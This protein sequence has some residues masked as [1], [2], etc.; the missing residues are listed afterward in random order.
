[1]GRQRKN[2]STTYCGVLLQRPLRAKKAPRPPRKIILSYRRGPR[3]CRDNTAGTRA[4]A[5]IRGRSGTLLRPVKA[6]AMAGASAQGV[7]SIRRTGTETRHDDLQ[8]NYATDAGARNPA[9]DPAPA[10]AGGRAGHPAPLSPPGSRPLSGGPCSVAVSRRRC[11]KPCRAM[12]WP[13]GPW[14]EVLLDDRPEG[15][16]RRVGRPY[17]SVARR[18]REPRPTRLLAGP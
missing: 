7:P 5:G 18:R 15:R 6:V 16:P 3:F 13:D 11:G 12:S 4:Q 10:A 1:M 17:R 14:R 8:A 9:P 2:L